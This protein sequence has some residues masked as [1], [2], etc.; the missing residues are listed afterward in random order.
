MLINT[1]MSILIS[2]FK[3][4]LHLL[5]CLNKVYEVKLNISYKNSARES[6]T[7]DI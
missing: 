4:Y 7:D 3:Q 5:T 2:T 1:K 6:T